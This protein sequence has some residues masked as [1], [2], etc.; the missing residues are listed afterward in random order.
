M[1]VS[2]RQKLSF[3]ETPLK[4]T[5]IVSSCSFIVLYVICSSQHNQECTVGEA[6]YTDG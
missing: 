6:R 2:K 4:A 5:S 3:N 1:S